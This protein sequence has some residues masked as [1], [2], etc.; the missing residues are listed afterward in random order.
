[1]D[2]FETIIFY[3]DRPSPEIQAKLKNVVRLYSSSKNLTDNTF[4]VETREDGVRDKFF[5]YFCDSA[6][7]GY[8]N[9]VFKAPYLAKLQYVPQYSIVIRS[10]TRV[11]AVQ[12]II[13]ETACEMLEIKEGL[14]KLPDTPDSDSSNDLYLKK[15]FLSGIPG[16]IIEVEYESESGSVVTHLVDREFLENWIVLVDH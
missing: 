3:K 12:L 9:P 6:D 10:N 16:N 1:M 4:G 15:D 11:K 2:V 7:E 5:V 8:L 13:A 14:V